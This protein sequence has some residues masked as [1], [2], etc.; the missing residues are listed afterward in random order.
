MKGGSKREILITEIKTFEQFRQNGAS[1]KN[2][3]LKGLD[4]RDKKVDWNRFVIHNTTFLGC[5]LS[6]EEE[7]LLRRRGA[8]L[9]SAPPTLPYQ[10]FRHGLYSWQELMEGFSE[11]E[12][13]STDLQIYRHFS[14]TRFNPNI[15]EALWQR[16]H[17][18]SIDDAL[19]QLL[20]FDNE[21]MTRR[22]CVGFMGG[23]S[24]RR[25]DLFY[26]KTVLTA[27][28]LAENG[29]FI[30]SGGGPG[31]MEATNLGAY[32]R[33]KEE[34]ALLDAMKILKKAPH[35]RDKGYHQQALEVLDKYPNGA[36]T[37][38]I[39]TWFYGHEPSNLFASHIAKYF[40]NSI[41]ED[42]LLAISLY[43]IVCA[44]GSAGTT[45]EIFMDA[46]QNHYGT[47]NYYSPMV[48]LGRQRYEIETLIFPL[49]KQ[50]AWGKKY[51]DMLFVT[52][53][54]EEVLGFL[55]GRP[56]VRV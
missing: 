3:T 1:L 44:P 14:A 4:F 16:I 50:L 10:P 27:K 43:G 2:C 38:A 19:R 41:R 55:K 33:G 51:Y 6:L 47:F 8:Y 13:R 12:D 48:F 30:V 52:D 36:E 53:E 11:E 46:T 37:L 21:G 32:F 42:T 40:S 54:P 23:H 49:L 28:L 24:T 29:Y 34:A 17:D 31:I 35:Y 22:P 15:N 25:D 5:G 26:K 20:E 9:Y 39:P 7:I 56:P 45:Q 18:H